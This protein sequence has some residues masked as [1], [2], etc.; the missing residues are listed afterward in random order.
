ML[1]NKSHPN[2]DILNR[3][4]IR[5]I[6]DP[7]YAPITPHPDNEANREFTDRILV[8]LSEDG[9]EKA[10]KEYQTRDEGINLLDFRM[11][12]AGFRYLFNLNEPVIALTVFQF[13]AGIFPHSAP[14]LR[15]LAEAYMETGQHEMAVEYFKSSL[16][17]DPDSP[18]AKEMVEQLEMRRSRNN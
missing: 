6:F 10:L 4:I 14:A 16:A 5:I 12:S 8:I 7:D 3:E 2:F 1:S 11:R 15:G 13:N 9:P 18:F 17:I